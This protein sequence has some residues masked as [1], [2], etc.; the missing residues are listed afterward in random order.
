MAPRKTKRTATE[1]LV[2]A[3]D[4]NVSPPKKKKT[5]ANTSK[6]KLKQ[7][8][9]DKQEENVVI[10]DSASPPKKSRPRA[11]NA[12]TKADK[13]ESKSKKI[14]QEG[15][16]TAM[17]KNNNADEAIAGQ[18]VET[19]ARGKSVARKAGTKKPAVTKLEIQVPDA[20][21]QRNEVAIEDGGDIEEKKTGRSAATKRNRRANE[22]TE[23]SQEPVAEQL[24]TKVSRKRKIAET[25]VKTEDAKVT[26]E[27]P[28]R[29]SRVKANKVEMDIDNACK[30]LTMGSFYYRYYTKLK[31]KKTE[32][33]LKKLTK[34]FYN[35]L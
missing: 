7:Q 26:K 14:K 29:K 3:A 9:T 21:R 15:I 11:K 20:K 24:A 35:I 16:A 2:V 32:F 33:P 19:K 12:A 25:I 8:K 13:T 6:E 10:N 1:N 4:S 5:T 27:D 28:I 34:I 31:K 30:F 23:E 17:V 22:P 18:V